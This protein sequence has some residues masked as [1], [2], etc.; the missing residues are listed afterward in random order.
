MTY[1]YIIGE[2]FLMETMGKRLSW[3]RERAGFS[4]ARQAALRHHWGYSTY[5]AHENGQNDYDDKAAARYAK[6]FKV[7]AGWLLTGEGSPSPKSMKH[8][9]VNYVA[10]GS[11]LVPIDDYPQ[12]EGIEEV[13]LPAGVPA[14]AVVVKVKGESMHPRYYDGEYLVYIRDGRSPDELVGRECVVELVDGRKMVKMVRRGSKKG[15]FRLESFNA[16]PIEDVKI[17]WAGYVWRPG[18]SA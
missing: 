17:R 1:V 10:G 13:E 7:S 2:N 15:L 8:P 16:A 3:A 9:V 4:S 6:A 18:I 11:E 5:A 12:G 14:N